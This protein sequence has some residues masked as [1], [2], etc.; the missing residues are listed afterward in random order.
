MVRLIEQLKTLGHDDVQVFDQESEYSYTV[1]DEVELL[2]NLHFARGTK[3]LMS[4]VDKLNAKRLSLRIAQHLGWERTVPDWLRDGTSFFRA[5]NRWREQI[6]LDFVIE[7]QPGPAFECCLTDRYR[8]R[9][10]RD[11]EDVAFGH[12]NTMQEATSRAWLKVLIK[13][14]RRN[15]ERKH[16]RGR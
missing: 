16:S 7:S 14:T 15:Y 8:R 6:G 12:G 10:D 3:R 11:D 5:F 1:P 13:R 9:G 2:R 4:A